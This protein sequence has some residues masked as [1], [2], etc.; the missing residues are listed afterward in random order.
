MA[1]RGRP[2]KKREF[3]LSPTMQSAASRC[4]LNY[5]TLQ[6]AK[7]ADCKA[8][9]TN[10]TVNC[11]E[12]AAWLKTAK[13]QRITDSLE[14]APDSIIESAL[15]S[16]A[17]RRRKEIQ[18]LKEVNTLVP[19]DQVKHAYSAIAKIYV[20]RT[21][22]LKQRLHLLFGLSL[23]ELDKEIS[24]ILETLSGDALQKALSSAARNDE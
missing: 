7:A 14:S 3:G 10:G 6:A 18:F 1:K 12:L 2:K 16:R 11:D 24:P 15:S 17:V 22:S 9:K 4:K 20:S 8:F 23:E 13:G 5:E 21:A 19:I